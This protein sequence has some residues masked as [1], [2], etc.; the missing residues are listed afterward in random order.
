MSF[1][2]G[3]FLLSESSRLDGNQ[4]RLVRYLALALVWR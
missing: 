2:M 4:R 1:G 3:V